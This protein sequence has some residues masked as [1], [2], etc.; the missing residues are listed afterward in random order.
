[1][2]NDELDRKFTQLKSTFAELGARSAISVSLL[3]RYPYWDENTWTKLYGEWV[4]GEGRFENLGERYDP[5]MATPVHGP[6]SP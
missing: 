5:Q 6:A 1:M 2:S 3:G 4:N